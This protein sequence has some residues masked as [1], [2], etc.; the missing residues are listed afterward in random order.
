MWEPLVVVQ[1]ELS[2]LSFPCIQY[3][4]AVQMQAGNGDFRMIFATIA[5][6]RF[7]SSGE[8]LTNILFGDMLVHPEKSVCSFH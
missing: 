5:E 3:I 2:L 8:D 7:V 4:F 1:C 6:K